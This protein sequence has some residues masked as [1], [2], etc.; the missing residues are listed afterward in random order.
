MIRACDVVANTE[1]FAGLERDEFY[2][3]CSMTRARDFQKGDVIAAEGDS[4]GSIGIIETGEVAMQKYTSGG[5]YTTI[6]LF[7][8][9]DYFGEDL[10]FAEDQKYPY[11]LEAVS[12]V[13][14][15]FLSKETVTALMDKCPLVKNN[16]LRILS[17]RVR[18]QNR[19]IALL[20]QKS[21]RQKI[22][23]YLLELRSERNGADK[24]RLPGSKEVI[25]KLLAMPRPSFSRELSQMVKDGLILVDGR[26]IQILNL[27]RME[28]DIVEGYEISR[29]EDI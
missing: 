27:E 17:E 6:G 26:E 4:C 3:F 20:S 28:K 25:A 13:Q 8:P 22:A 15:L 10:L 19:R 9:G 7:E 2:E 18:I 14:V 1:L 21:I 16:Y 24:I 23:F 29:E 5:E 11:T 12:T